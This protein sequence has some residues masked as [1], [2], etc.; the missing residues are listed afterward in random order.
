MRAHA[1]SLTAGRVCVA[2]GI[3]VTGPHCSEP[4]AQRPR[5]AQQ[6]ACG[7][8]LKV[9]W[10][11]NNLGL[12]EDGELPAD[13]ELSLGSRIKL[14]SAGVHRDIGYAYGHPKLDGKPR[15]FAVQV[16]ACPSH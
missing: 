8:G 13:M 5:R 3:H 11:N 4:E 12:G 16:V 1:L 15:W 10:R 7:Q 14:W 2:H 6:Q 9:Y